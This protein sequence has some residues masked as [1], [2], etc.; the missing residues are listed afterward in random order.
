MPILSDYMEDMDVLKEKIEN[1]SEAILKVINLNHLLSLS[2]DQKIEYIKELLFDFW[3]T[4]E[5]KI[6]SAMKM[7]EAKA[8][9]L[10]NK[11]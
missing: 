9:K 6:K 7:G 5:S 10:L 11:I 4:Q 2:R 3:E 1:E 8:N